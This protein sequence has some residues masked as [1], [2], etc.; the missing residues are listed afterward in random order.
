MTVYNAASFSGP[1]NDSSISATN[2]ENIVNIAINVLNM[3]GA[4]TITNM[5]SGAAGSKT[6]TLT[7]KQAGAVFLTVRQIYDS[8]WKPRGTT[9][10]QG[11]SVTLADVLAN[12]TIVATIEKI[13]SRLSEVAFVVAE[14]T[15]GIE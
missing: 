15:S 6:V 13:A 4:A 3:F 8:F 11:Q 5:N 7:S 10:T 12:P 14:D 1:L 2:M 9:V